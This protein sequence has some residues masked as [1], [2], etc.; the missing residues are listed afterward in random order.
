[1]TEQQK[2]LLLQFFW[3]KGGN[4]FT[5]PQQYTEWLLSFALK[6]KADQRAEV[7]TWLQARKTKNTTDLQNLDKQRTEAETALTGENTLID[8]LSVLL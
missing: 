5:N 4:V 1:M 3:E 6:S 7:Q 2:Q 8:S